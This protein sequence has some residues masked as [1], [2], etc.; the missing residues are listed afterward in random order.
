MF[1]IWNGSPLDAKIQRKNSFETL[2]SKNKL[3]VR[4]IPPY[5]NGKFILANI[6]FHSIIRN[7]SMEV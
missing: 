7:L 3:D 5:T 1:Y 2:E 4:E 6:F